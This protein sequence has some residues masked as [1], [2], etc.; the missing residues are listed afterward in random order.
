MGAPA[1]LRQSLFLDHE[2]IA[3]SPTHRRRLSE[4]AVLFRRRPPATQARTHTCPTE[5]VHPQP[6][7]Q[8]NDHFEQQDFK[9]ASVRRVRLW[10]HNTGV[11]R[12]AGAFCRSTPALDGNAPHK[13]AGCD[14]IEDLCAARWQ[15]G[16]HRSALRSYI[17]R[18]SR[19]P[20]RATR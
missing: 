13:H 4:R 9:S 8:N 17:A 10:L 18:K 2:A 19:A 3:V 6:V 7:T 20:G 5:P 1:D 15:R 12:G 14:Q 11:A 16:G